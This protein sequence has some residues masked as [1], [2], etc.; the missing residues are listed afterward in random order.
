FSHVLTLDLADIPG[1]VLQNYILEKK[2][3]IYID[4]DKVR[5][6]GFEPVRARIFS[7]NF[8]QRQRIIQHDPDALALV[9]RSM[10]GLRESGL[11]AL[12]SVAESSLPDPEFS[13]RI[14]ADKLIPCMRYERIA[15]I[16]EGLEFRYLTL[17]TD[18]PENMA[19]SLRR[20]IA[21]TVLEILWR[22]PDIHPDHLQYLNGI[23]LVETSSWKRCQ[24]W[25][26]V[27]SFY[28]PKDSCIKIRQDQT[29]SPER[30]DAALLIAL[31]QSLLGNYCQ[32]KGM[33][34]VFVLERQVGRLY[35]LS[36]RK[37]QELKSFLS[38]DELDAYLQLSR[39]C[40]VKEEE[41]CYTRLVNG[42]EG[43]TPPGLLFGL[44]FA[45]YLDNRFAS[46]VEYKMSVMKN[47]PSDLIPEQ[48]RIMRRREKLIC[49]FRERIFRDQFS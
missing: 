44:L 10:W 38:P 47:I 21:A 9:V 15:R 3:P 8:L 19:S 2:E 17:D 25:D 7:G 5:E 35:R 49:F 34:D 28:D 12:P 14:S 27:F 36:I 42:K 20:K 11:L 13:V 45:W 26:N 24:Q 43:F 46:N 1:S 39:M 22:H 37:R 18:L 31:G 23:C 48:V 41:R 16:V 6:L 4:S 30:M 29:G 32:E 40:P 33:E